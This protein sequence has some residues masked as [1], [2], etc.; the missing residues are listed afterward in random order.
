M[1]SFHSVIVSTA[2]VRREIFYLSSFA[3]LHSFTMQCQ[4]M[5]FLIARCTVGVAFSSFFRGFLCGYKYVE[6][7]L[8]DNQLKSLES[9]L[10][11]TT[12]KYSLKRW[13]GRPPFLLWIRCW[14]SQSPQQRIL[15]G[16]GKVSDKKSPCPNL[17]SWECDPVMCVIHSKQ[18]DYISKGSHPPHDAFATVII[19]I[20]CA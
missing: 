12:G 18:Q 11:N 4:W 8:Q 16:V 13:I 15:A 17:V 14:L 10:L 19:R 7:E 6:F 2:P 5:N 1:R 20:I 3:Y 9:T